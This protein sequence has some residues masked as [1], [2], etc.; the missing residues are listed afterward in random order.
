MSGT[1]PASDPPHSTNSA[2]A[3]PGPQSVVGRKKK[4]YYEEFSEDVEVDP[5]SFYQS[6][7]HEMEKVVD[8]FIS[9]TFRRLP[10]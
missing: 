6:V 10:K 7:P 5:E 1:G 2:S 9:K 4:R 8:D 3:V